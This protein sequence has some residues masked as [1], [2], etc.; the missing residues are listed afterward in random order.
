MKS[1]PVY[2]VDSLSNKNATFFI[3]P[4]QRNYEWSEDLCSVLLT[5]IEATAKANASGQ[6]AE[7]FFGSIVYV[8]EEAGFGKPARYVLTDGQQRITTTMLLLMALRDCIESEE[9]STAIQT[10]YIQNDKAGDD[11]EYKIK[12]KQVETDW[13]AYKLLA[14]RSEVPSHLQNSAVFRN[15]SFFMKA[16]KNRS[17]KAKKD[18]LEKGLS[19]LGVVAI[20][21][22]P[23]ENPWENPQEI[24]ESMNSL[25]KP[26]TLADL[27]RN[28]LLMGKTAE[29]QD[30][31]YDKYWLRLE[32]RLPGYLSSFI[33]DWMQADQHKAYKV[34][35]ETNYKQLYAQ[36]KAVASGRD[37]QALIADLQRFSRPYAIAV[38]LEKSGVG[39]V[40]QQIEDLNKTNITSIRSYLAE[41]ISAW[42]DEKMS[43]ADLEALLIAVRTYVLRRRVLRLTTAENKIYPTLGI[44][45]PELLQAAD[46]PKIFF[47]Q[48]SSYEY[49]FRLPND[50]ELRAGLEAANFYNL[51]K[52]GNYPKLLLSLIEE[53]LTKSRPHWNDEYLQL[54]HIMPQKLTE[55]WKKELGETWVEDHQRLMNNIG[56]I[57]LIRHNQELGNKP[58]VEKKKVYADNSGLQ[59]AQ[60]RVTDSSRWDSTAIETRRD[61]LIGL[62]LDRILTIP[63][64]MRNANNWKQERTS[65][66]GFNS[67]RVLNQ[68]IGETISYTSNEEVQAKVVSDSKVL[69]ENQEWYLSSLTKELK[70]REGI[71]SRSSA[72]QGAS[73][74]TWGGQKLVDLDT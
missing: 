6:R 47:K 64:S 71:L 31:L 9:I 51:G 30:R 22:S 12:L 28:F 16:L 63:D 49:A 36:F 45:L 66:G 18:L 62:L 56:N 72:Y 67:R 43:S 15:Y 21:L 8:V 50:N 29:E 58:F 73:Y 35:S 57:S 44:K 42:L 39:K 1:D 37:V 24:F 41:L 32:K 7:H 33:R 14:L 61:Y 74:W 20:Q 54:E 4:Y 13:E 48:M 40:D 3:P 27:V 68:L 60:N 17:E 52:K 11:T 65:S 5:D 38:G 53:D 34:A 70:R 69:F 10:G 2:L 46:K 19:K 26:L 59:V 23:S 25:G 55:A